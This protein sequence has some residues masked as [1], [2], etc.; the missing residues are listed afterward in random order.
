VLEVMST[1]E[2]VSRPM[3]RLPLIAHVLLNECSQYAHVCVV[4]CTIYIALPCI[5]ALWAVLTPLLVGIVTGC[6]AVWILGLF[7]TAALAIS[8]GLCCRWR[9]AR[10]RFWSD[11]DSLDSQHS[12]DPYNY[13]EL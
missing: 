11:S 1:S 2:N 9:A 4:P 10:R 13:N 5:C 8:A 7:A 12:G 6:R 3:H